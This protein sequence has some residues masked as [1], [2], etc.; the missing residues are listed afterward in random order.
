MDVARRWLESRS[1][2][3]GITRIRKTH[4]PGHSPGSIGLYDQ[5]N[6]VLFAG[7]AVY[8]GE[9]IDDLQH[10]HVEQYV[11]TMERLARLPVAVV[12]AG[13]YDSFSQSRVRRLIDEYLR[14]RRRRRPGCPAG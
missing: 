11:V 10:S 6:G 2:G 3:D 7:D 12:H 9:L 4:V 8:V 5:R 13:H 14:R 1:L